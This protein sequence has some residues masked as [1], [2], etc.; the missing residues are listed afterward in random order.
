[1]SATLTGLTPNTT[2]H[3]RA[4][5]NNSAGITDGADLTFTTEPDTSAPTDLSLSPAT[6][7]EN[8]AVGTTVGTLTATD[9]DTA[10]GDTASFALV[11][12]V[13]DTDNASF[14]IVGDVLQTSATFDF[15]VKNSYSVRVQVT[16]IGGLTFEKALT[17]A[18]GNINEPPVYTGYGF[19]CR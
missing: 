4:V 2:Y 15:E 12:G 1:V 13:G 16:D 19:T 11:T 9:P 7:L 6:V 10:L 8:Q 18:I 3:F 5:G 14:S 17:I